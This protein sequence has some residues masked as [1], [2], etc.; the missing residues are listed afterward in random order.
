MRRLLGIV[1]VTVLALLTACGPVPSRPSAADWRSSAQMTVDDAVAQV[2]T[3]KLLL[4]EQEKGHI[5]GG[6][7]VAT[8]VHA[9][10]LLGTSTEGLLSQQVPKGME[11]KAARLADLLDQAE[12]A[13]REAR[14]ALVRGDPGNPQQLERLQKR[15]ERVGGRL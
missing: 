11:K 3:A 10:E 2:A 4:E 5:L 6:Y 14:S 12:T 15:L 7:A 9:E 8:V 13:V 1:L